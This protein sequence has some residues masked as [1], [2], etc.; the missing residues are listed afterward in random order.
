MTAQTPM[1]SPYRQPLPFAGDS[2][3][4]GVADQLGEAIAGDSDVQRLLGSANPA[5]LRVV[6]DLKTDFTANGA[7]RLRRL[8]WSVQYSA[9]EQGQAFEAR[10]WSYYFK[11]G[12][13]RWTSFP[14]DPHLA[15]AGRALSQRA[16]ATVLRY[17]PL[18]RLTFSCETAEGVPLAG[19][20]KQA[21]RYGDAVRNLELLTAAAA[22]RDLTFRIPSLAGVDHANHAFFQTWCS[23]ENLA[24]A[25]TPD[26]A[27]STLA[28]VGSV[29]AE[30]HAL[31]SAGL[32]A[33][34]NSALLDAAEGAARLLTAI[35]PKDA[36]CLARSIERLR[37]S[38]PPDG[39]PDF[40]HGD[41]VLSQMLAHGDEWSMVDFD[42]CQ[43]ASGYRDLAFLLASLPSDVPYFA[44]GH[45]ASPK[46]AV[47]EDCRAAL[48]DAYCA[49]RGWRAD[50][51]VLNWHLA[52][53]ELHFL[54]LMIRKG[55]YSE[56]AFKAGLAKLEA[57]SASATGVAEKR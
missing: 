39:A 9:K 44:D 3:F 5:N 15:S 2:A 19:K 38:A 54:M 14:D 25:V 13:G 22:K 45:A 10:T 21:D 33:T 20:I 28:R 41:F 23:G 16:N 7:P 31:P 6:S 27:A 40:C 51:T 30:L 34:A 46:P 57:A 53:C 52:C 1:Q 50:R 42:L 12:R 48:V 32:E 8:Y 17:V 49:A 29:L 26:N 43:R 55:T 36:P 35:L 4:R 47:L 37:A 56:A 11:E 24:H 18:R